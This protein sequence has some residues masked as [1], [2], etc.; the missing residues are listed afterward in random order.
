VA[1]GSGPA[2][3]FDALTYLLAAG[4]L[5]RLPLMT[6]AAAPRPAMTLTDIRDGWTEFRRTPWVW[7]VTC[8]FCLVNLV[9]TGTWQ[10]LGP[11]LTKQ[12]SGE[13]AWG[14]VLSARSVG[15]LVMG[16][17]M[18]RL[19]VRHLLRLGLLMGA[20][21][22]L[23]LLVLGAQPHASWIPI[24]QLCVGPLAQTFGGFCVARTAGVVYAVAVVIPLASAAV[25]RLPHIPADR[26]NSTDV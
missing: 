4:C 18:Y 10:I 25:R 1:V 16:A 9:Q 17:L 26:A 15:L 12:L 20:L 8:S 14:F 13:A 24:G 2:I 5:V 11:A 7:V 6:S 23:P 21:G 19:V 3:A 22:A